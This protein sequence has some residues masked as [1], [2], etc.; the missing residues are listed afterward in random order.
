LGEVPLPPFVAVDGPGEGGSGTVARAAVLATGIVT[1]PSF[2]RR[3]EREIIWAGVG[4][5]KLW[6]ADSGTCFTGS[7][8]RTTTGEVVLG[9]RAGREVENLVDAI[10]TSAGATSRLGAVRD[11]FTSAAVSTFGSGNTITLSGTF[12]GVH[13]TTKGTGVCC[14]RGRS[15]GT[16]GCIRV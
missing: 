6:D 10:F 14:S 9:G 12:T 1:L 16:S 5:V 3:S 11:A 15:G 7:G 13:L 2:R 8:R 4:S